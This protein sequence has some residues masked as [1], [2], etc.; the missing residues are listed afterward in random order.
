M[1]WKSDLTNNYVEWDP[2]NMIGDPH[3]LP[4]RWVL[5]LV[6]ATTPVDLDDSRR[7]TYRERRS[8]INQLHG[9]CWTACADLFWVRIAASLPL[10][11]A[12]PN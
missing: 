5:P 1:I 2:G 7:R 3:N 4:I 12:S 11:Q 10:P 8:G 9:S 6:C